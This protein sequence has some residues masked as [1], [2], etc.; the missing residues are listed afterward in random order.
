MNY[1]VESRFDDGKLHVALISK[2]G[3]L[4]TLY[5]HYIRGPS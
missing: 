2:M 3:R 1:G 4:R 5:R